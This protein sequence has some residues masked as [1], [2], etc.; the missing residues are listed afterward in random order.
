MLRI[1]F[2]I[3]LQIHP[4]IRRCL[5]CRREPLRRIDG[6]GRFFFHKTLDARARYADMGGELS[7]RQAIRR[8]IFIAQDAA[9]MNSEFQKRHFIST[10]FSIMIVGDFNIVGAA[11]LPR[12]TNPPLIVNADGMLALPV[13][14]QRVQAVAGRRTQ[15]AERSR[16][17]DHRQFVLCGFYEFGRKALW[18]FTRRYRL[19]EPAF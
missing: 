10:K 8:Q 16:R 11:V 13:A 6:H 5:K 1:Q 7:C 19:C 18:S 3:R 12:K 9:R 2:V 14:L 15:I 17:F 4:E